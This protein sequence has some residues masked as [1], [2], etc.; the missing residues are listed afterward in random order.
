MAD[1]NEEGFETIVFRVFSDSEGGVYL[2][3][4]SSKEKVEVR[5][6]VSA[7]TLDE[8]KM[9]LV[10]ESKEKMEAE[11]ARLEGADK[12]KLTAQQEANREIVAALKPVRPAGFLSRANQMFTLIFQGLATTLIVL[13]FIALAYKG[14][15]YSSEHLPEPV[16]AVVLVLYLAALVLCIYMI[17]TEENRRR[18]S[19]RIRVWFGPRGLLVLPCLIL[20]V[21]GSVFASL[22]L[23]LHNHGWVTMQ[24]CAGRPIAE[25]SLMDFYMWNFL[26][27]VPLLK[28]NEA[29]KLNEPLCYTQT[30]VGLLILLFQAL[31]VIPSINTIRYYWKNRRTL[32]A[33]P[34]TYVHDLGWTPDV[35]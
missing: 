32:N 25:G 31:V 34:S 11:R 13:W 14:V 27:L 4:E 8:A 16:H 5:R 2:M 29:L 3:Y 15:E 22:T 12:E 1:K 19:D 30:R 21:A 10:N 17:A 35:E 18:Q 26:K 23:M 6:P 28:L 24:A 33:P 7:A 9:R 20:V